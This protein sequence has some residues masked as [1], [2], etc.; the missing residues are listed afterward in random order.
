MK[1]IKSKRKG[2][3][4]LDCYKKINKKY[5]VI[6]HRG[7]FHLSCYFKHLKIRINYLKKDLKEFNKPKYKKQMILENLK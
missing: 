4:C 7:F 6:T 5:K 2:S 1:I 3:I